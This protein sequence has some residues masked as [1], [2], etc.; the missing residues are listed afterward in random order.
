MIWSG[1]SK[2]KSLWF[3]LAAGFQKPLRNMHNIFSFQFSSLKMVQNRVGKKN[4]ASAGDAA[5]WVVSAPQHSTLTPVSLCDRTTHRFLCPSFAYVAITS[6]N[7]HFNYYIQHFILNSFCSSDHWLDLSDSSCPPRA[8]FPNRTPD[9]QRAGC[10]LPVRA[11][12]NARKEVARRWGSRDECLMSL[13]GA[14]VFSL[15]RHTKDSMDMQSEFTSRPHKQAPQK[16]LHC[17]V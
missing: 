11:P 17:V 3:M 16:P 2:H 9:G 12:P 1:L 7:A 6:I 8:P 4:P 10:L 5:T 15:S 14:C 13:T